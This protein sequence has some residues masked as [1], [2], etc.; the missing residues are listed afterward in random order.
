MTRTVCFLTILIIALLSQA[1]EAP[2]LNGETDIQKKKAQSYFEVGEEFVLNFDS[3]AK[4][5][6]HDIT[7][8]FISVDEYRCPLD[9]MCV[10]AGN[11]EIELIV[12]IG[13]NYKKVSLNTHD[14]LVNSFTLKGYKVQLKKL[15]PYPQSSE[16][17]TPEEKYKATLII[18]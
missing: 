3:E 12:I 6:V 18:E 4:N 13:E 10:W 8:R 2:I 14:D 11:A 9:V 16:D 15:D 1:C 7:V 5:E 17:L